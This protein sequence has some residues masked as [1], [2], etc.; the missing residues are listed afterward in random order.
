MGCAEAI[1]FTEVRA[2]KQWDALRQQ[3]HTR[4]DQWLDTLEQQLHEPSPTLSQVSDTVWGL[5]QSLTGG[6]TETIVEQV[7]EGERQRTQASCPRCARVLKVQ[8]PVWRTVE[9]MVGPVEL[10]RPSFYC[11][12]CRVGL[13]PFDDALGLVAGCQQLDRQHAAAKLVTDVPYDTAQSLFDDL[14]GMHF[15]SERLHTVTNHVGAGLTVVD[16]APSRQ[17]SERRIASMSAGRLRRTA[18]VRGV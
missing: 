10:E 8:E 16:V 4:F 7:H 2:S 13:Y 15:G 1:S 12:S 11:R 14:T 17:E 3:L 6:I 9:T 5:R 18:F